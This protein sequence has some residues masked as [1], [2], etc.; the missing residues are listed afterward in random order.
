MRTLNVGLR[1]SDLERSLAFYTAV[2]YMIVGTV[3]GTASGS[4]AMLRLPGDGFGTTELVYDQLGAKRRC[5][6]HDQGAGAAPGPK[7]PATPAPAEVILVNLRVV[8]AAG[9]TAVKVLPV[10]LSF[11]VMLVQ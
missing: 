10:L 8:L 2:G 11:R 7:A 4:P 9:M 3:E 5:H 1:V 6:L